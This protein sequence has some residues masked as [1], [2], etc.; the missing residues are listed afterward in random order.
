[1]FSVIGPHLSDSGTHFF[2]DRRNEG[3]DQISQCWSSSN[4]LAD[5]RYSICSLLSCTGLPLSSTMYSPF[6]FSRYPLSSSWYTISSS[7]CSRSGMEVSWLLSGQ[8]RYCRCFGW[9]WGG[10]KLIFNCE[11]LYNFKHQKWAMNLLAYAQRLLSL[12][13]KIPCRERSARSN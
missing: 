1:M 8:H 12:R 2:L 6:S 7:S 11:S 10:I 4:I 9:G 3:R 5:L 13:V